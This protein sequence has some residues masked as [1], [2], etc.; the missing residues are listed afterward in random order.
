MLKIRGQ[1]RKALKKC[2]K[3]GKVEDFVEEN[4]SD[5]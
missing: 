5:G 4:E 3:T 1:K 2:M